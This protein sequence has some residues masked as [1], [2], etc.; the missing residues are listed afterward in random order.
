MLRC[1]CYARFSSDLQRETSL[2]DQI[3]GC[4]TYA[5]QHGWVWLDS[6]VFTDAALSGSSLEGRVGLQALLTAAAVTP[7]GFD[8]LLVDDSSRVA[9]DLADALRILQRLRFAGVRVVYISQGID[10]ASE[11]A[12]TLIAVHGLVDGLY[13]R[14][15]SAKVKRGLRGQIA[16]GFA[17]GSVTFGYRTIPI[18]DPHRAGHTLGS[19]VEIDPTQADVVRQIFTWFADGVSYTNII[20]RLHDAGTPGPRGGSAHGIWR[21]AAVRRLLSNPKYRGLLLWGTTRSERK[22]G[23]RSRVARPL[24]PSEWQMHERPDL[25]IVD[26]ALWER[27]QARRKT[28]SSLLDEHRQP[29]R[30]LL[31]GRPAVAGN[32]KSPFT[33]FLIC[34]VCGRAVSVVSNHVHFSRRYRYFGCSNYARNGPA[35]CP[36]R[37]T[38]RVEETEAALLA[39]L[40]AEVLKPE[41]LAY[42]T[43]RLAAAM[44]ALV[45]ERPVREAELRRQIETARSKIA[46][47]LAAVE[48][49]NASVSILLALQEREGDVERFQAE[50]AALREPIRDHRLAVLPTWVQSQLAD[51]AS[52]IQQEPA[53]AEAE[54]ERLQIRF[55]L[56][57]VYE[58]PSGQRP[59][60]RAIG[61]GAFELLTG[62]VL[63]A[64]G[65]LLR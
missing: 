24:P 39:G 44:Q 58:V 15:M 11:Q 36:N 31:R 17:T 20:R 34:G 38:A 47:L 27:V 56:H 3:R 51:V 30:T 57:P 33:G 55:T 28:Q 50:L 9:R 59:Y 41:T 65:A 8:V 22:P 42:V 60:L 52:L 48:S 43:E 21:I 23:S 18:P 12:E 25:R 40:Q 10:S 5:D 63:P 16:R 29:G 64:S 61:E 62:A 1:T 7:R 45:D 26:D 4:R 54:F 46:H 35:A 2:E 53:A 32:R 37:V 13:L 6:H 19:R 49:G 14:E